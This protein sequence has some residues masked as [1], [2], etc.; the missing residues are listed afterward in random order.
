M[1][2]RLQD[3]VVLLRPV[4]LVDPADLGDRQWHLDRMVWD[5]HNLATSHSGLV[6]LVLVLAVLLVE[7]DQAGNP[8]L[9]RSDGLWQR[10]SRAIP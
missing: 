4:D 8:N 7:D 1:L 10:L 3:I 5:L 2:H 9:D 6:V